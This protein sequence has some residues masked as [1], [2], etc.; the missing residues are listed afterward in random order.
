MFINI[1]SVLS[2]FDITKAVDG[3]GN[4][5]TPTGEY[6]SGLTWFVLYLIHSA[7]SNADFASAT[8]FRS[9]VT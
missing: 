5:I 6:T 8:L 3:R 1:A 4:P 2:M 7:R 9:N